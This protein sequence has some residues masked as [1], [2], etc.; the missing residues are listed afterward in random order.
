MQNDLILTDQKRLQLYN[1]YLTSEM[2]EVFSDTL[3]KTGSVLDVEKIY[4]LTKTLDQITDYNNAYYNDNISIISDAEYDSIFRSFIIKI[5]D[6]PNL[7][8]LIAP[9]MHPGAKPK[10]TSCRIQH[11]IPMLSL[12]NAFSNKEIGVFLRQVQRFLQIA[13]IPEISAEPKI[14]GM[15]FSAVYQNGKLKYASTRGNGIEGE[16][17]TAN[18]LQ[19]NHVP[20]NINY[21]GLVEVRGEIYALLGTLQSG[22]SNLRNYASGSIRQLDPVVTADRNLYYFVYQCFSYLEGSLFRTHTESLNFARDLGFIVNS[23][24]IVS[25]NLED[26]FNFY[27]EVLNTRSM[28]DYE[29]DGVVYKINNLSLQKRLDSTNHHPRWAIAHKFK[30]PETITVVNDVEFSVSRTGKITPVAILEPVNLGGIVISRASLYNLDEIQRLQ[31]GIGDEVIIKRAG[32]VIPKIVSVQTKHNTDTVEIPKYCPSCLHTL[33]QEGPF[34][35]CINGNCT[36]ILKM[37]IYHFVSVLNIEGLGKKTIAIF[38]EKGLL[39]KVS[40]IF[41]LYYKREQM[42]QLLGFG[43]KAVDSLCSNIADSRTVKLETLIYALGIENVGQSHA[44]TLAKHFQSIEQLIE[45]S[46]VTELS[47]INNIG[48]NIAR[49]IVCFFSIQAN[50]D[51]VRTLHSVL[52]IQ[53]NEKIDSLISGKKILFTGILRSMTRI[54]AKNITEKKGGC[55]VNSISKNIDYLICGDKSGSKIQRAKELGIKILNEDEWYKLIE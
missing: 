29:V 22:F 32:E 3:R 53:Q 30:S 14:D 47:N 12:Q 28:L 5:E 49:N 24:T 38:V 21:K 42:L 4:S 39:G 35:K 46:N 6:D 7:A 36:E 25:N 48:V 8:I 55:V 43:E 26:L 15:S 37:Q 44:R 10:T 27:N 18:F 23:N 20:K 45:Y 52:T 31:I 2:R 1:Q 41:S 9:I 33:T 54:E 16:N 40:D 50:I 19:V 34:L 51:T 11:M 17:I 13:E